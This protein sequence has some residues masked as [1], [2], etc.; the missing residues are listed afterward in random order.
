MYPLRHFHSVKLFRCFIGDSELT[1][2]SCFLL[3]FHFSFFIFSSQVD[4]HRTNPPSFQYCCFRSIFLCWLLN[5]LTWYTTGTTCGEAIT[6]F[7]LSCPIRWV[8]LPP[9]S[10]RGDI[11][12]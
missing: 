5:S 10:S 12:C 9:S 2:H 6:I 7:F 8:L 11:Y 4:F 1:L 3:T